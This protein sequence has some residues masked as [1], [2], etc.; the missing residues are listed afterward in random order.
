MISNST[1]I[2]IVIVGATVGSTCAAI[3]SVHFVVSCSTSSLH[4]Q[5]MPLVG[6]NSPGIT[7]MSHIIVTPDR[8]FRVS[9][10]LRSCNDASCFRASVGQTTTHEPEILLSQNTTC[11]D[12]PRPSQ[13]A[14]L[15]LRRAAGSDRRGKSNAFSVDKGQMPKTNRNTLGEFKSGTTCPLENSI[16]SG[17]YYIDAIYGQCNNKLYFFT[18]LS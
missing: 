11:D 10:G 18:L 7:D 3:G 5:S 8:R 16:P 15:I 12:C 4:A 6:A 17:K 9:R 2:S 13:A 14:N 1:K